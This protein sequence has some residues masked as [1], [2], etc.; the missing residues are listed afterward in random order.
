MDKIKLNQL[1]PVANAEPT[2]VEF[3][4]AT[5]AIDSVIPYERVLDMLQWAIDNTVMDIPFISGAIAKIIRDEALVKFYTNLDME[6]EPTLARTYETYDLLMS[7]GVIEAVEQRVN[8]KQLAF[9][10]HA[11]QETVKSI[12]DYR[13]SA[14]GVIEALSKNA[15]FVSSSIASALDTLGSPESGQNIEHIFKLAQ[16]LA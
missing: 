5:I 3:G 16:D 11:L 6:A 10:D 15:D 9:F 7:H 12:V 1:G 14:A 4:D 2:Y 13:N 8:K